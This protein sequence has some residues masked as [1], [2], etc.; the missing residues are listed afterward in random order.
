MSGTPTVSI[1]I[2]VYNVE[3][4]LRRCLDSVLAQTFDDWEAICVD[5]GSTDKS[6]AILR[7]YAARDERFSIITQENSGQSAARNVAIAR[8][9]GE[10]ILFLDSDDFIHAQ[11]LE[12][13]CM[14]A[15]KNGADLVTFGYDVGFHRMMGRLVRAGI[16]LNHAMPVKRKRTYNLEHIRSK[17][18]SNL[19]SYATE[20]NHS[21]MRWGVRH[22]FPAMRLYRRELIADLPFIRGIIM[23]DFPWWSAVMLRRPKTVITKLPLYFYIPNTAS[24]LCSAKARR[25]I[26]GVI[27][28][29][30]YVYDLYSKYARPDE[31]S[32]YWREFFWPFVIIAVRKTVDLDPQDVAP[33]Q[34]EFSRLYARGLFNNPPNM[35]ARRYRKKIQQF[36]KTGV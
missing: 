8:A 30:E 19:L 7:K 27:A 23:E 22:C 15:R 14:L 9:R 5:D 36:I 24:T 12:I 25:M 21:I 16:D 32:R 4:Y 6:P 11:T 35:R 1:I 28:G 34:A 13:V 20:R 31:I 33:I 3:K 17:C 18:T 2:P 10:Y 29:L 26:E